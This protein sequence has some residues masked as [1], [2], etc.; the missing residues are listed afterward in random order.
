MN[1]LL[2]GP[3]HTNLAR[4]VVTNI[5]LLIVQQHAI[6]GLD[7]VFGSL[8]SFIVDKTIAFRAAVLIGSDFAGQDIT[9][10]RKSIV[11]G[12][13][14]SMSVYYLCVCVMSSEKR[15]LLSIASS[16]FLMKMLP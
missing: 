12:L 14:R 8:G 13:Q 16:K 7:R 5:D 10:S 3:I 2:L 4:N 15:T 9:E 11:Q 1:R 6:D